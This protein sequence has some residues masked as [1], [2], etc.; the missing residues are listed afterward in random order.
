MS[1]MARLLP[2]LLAGVLPS[3]ALGAPDRLSRGA[4]VAETRDLVHL[5][6]AGH[7]DPYSFGGGKI[8]FH[9]RYQQLLDAIPD[10]GMSVDAYATLLL[11]FIAR[12]GDGH[13][14]VY[15]PAWERAASVTFPLELDVVEQ[16]LV[17]SGVRSR[18]LKALLNARLEA[19]EGVGF[20]ELVERE[21][22]ILPFENEYHNLR[23]LVGSL[24]NVARLRLLV[25]EWSDQKTLR[26]AVLT[27]G[28]IR[29]ERAV[30]LG[31]GGPLIESPSRVELPS[32]DRADFAYRFLDDRKQT[33]LLRIDDMQTY[34]ECHE[35]WRF[36]G[37]AYA[38]LA[39]TTYERYHGR[40]PP[41]DLDRVIDALPSATELFRQLVVDMKRA[42]TKT[43]IIDL[44]ECPGGVSNIAEMLMYF[45]YGRAR[46]A[47]VLAES[48]QIRKH[49]TVY[50]SN[51]PGERFEPRDEGRRT[52]LTIEDYDFREE[53]NYSSDADLQARLALAR[54]ELDE[55]AAHMPTF[56]VEYESGA[57]EAYY[58]PANVVVLSDAGTFSSAFWML[59][60]F[61]KAGAR[62][63]GVPSGQAPNTFSDQSPYPLA[64]TG[65]TLYM[66][67]KLSVS[68]PRLPPDARVLVPDPLLTYEALAAHD[69]DP[70]TAV[71]LAVEALQP[72]AA[73]TSPSRSRGR[74]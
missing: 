35:H 50:Y 45:V 68:F 20:P 51:A 72:E 41:A 15:P 56:G 18:E 23:R 27:P 46:T 38:E 37:H 28:N 58:T 59:Q 36:Y 48:Y 69:F 16:R 10:E 12:I 54:R 11:P 42:D 7:P 9:R 47:Q 4:L 22:Q 74:P 57:H 17:V 66:S 8:A 67:S 53:R 63:V 29:L 60:C 70:N 40:R 73:T 64:R 14:Y 61:Y 30:T 43:L 2:L 19:V 1:P 26:L 71:L 21:K 32:T 25:P 65:L 49:S 62:V 24:T 39:R 44:R 13:T 5:L 34:R 6:E 52:P 31:A 3:T 33:V 55:M